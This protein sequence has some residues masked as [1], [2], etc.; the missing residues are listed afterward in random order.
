M[1]FSESDAQR[2]CTIKQPVGILLTIFTRIDGTEVQLLCGVGRDSMKYNLR[3]NFLCHEESGMS[4]AIILQA[5]SR[6]PGRYH[7]ML[8]DREPAV[9]KVIGR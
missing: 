5:A 4:G 1:V 9:Q 8:S 3:L 7:V 6:E 2:Q